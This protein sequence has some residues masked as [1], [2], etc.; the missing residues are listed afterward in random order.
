VARLSYF[1]DRKDKTGDLQ[2][3]GDQPPDPL[4]RGDMPDDERRRMVLQVAALLPYCTLRLRYPF[5]H[6]LS[7]VRTVS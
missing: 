6:D 7:S 1:R 2:L 3:I 5:S 4:Y